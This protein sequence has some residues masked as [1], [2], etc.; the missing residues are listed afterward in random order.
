MKK[1]LLKVHAVNAGVIGLVSKSEI[2]PTHF[3]P[4]QPLLPG[5]GYSRSLAIADWN[6]SGDPRPRPSYLAASSMS[7]P[8][9]A[10]GISWTHQ[11]RVMWAA[12]RYANVP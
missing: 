5:T 12:D 7:Q 4:R 10:F 6:L 2:P 11:R 1:S 9:G 3:A 8:R